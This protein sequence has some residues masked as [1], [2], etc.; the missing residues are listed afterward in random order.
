MTDTENGRQSASEQEILA[1]TPRSTGGKEAQAGVFV[2][3]GMSF[4]HR[5]PAARELPFWKMVRKSVPLFVL[6]FLGLSLANSL[7]WI[8]WLSETVGRPIGSDLKSVA[9]LLIELDDL[10]QSGLKVMN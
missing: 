8:G 1:A 10:L 9:K 5:D 6:F 3:V 2:I 4:A 7:G